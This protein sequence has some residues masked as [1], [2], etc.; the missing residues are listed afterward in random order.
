[1]HRRVGGPVA[2][3]VCT[4]HTGASSSNASAS[5]Q[6]R[7]RLASRQHLRGRACRPP[8]RA[9]ASAFRESAGAPG[10]CRAARPA[11]CLPWRARC[12]AGP[13][14]RGWCADLWPKRAHPAARWAHLAASAGQ[15]APAATARPTAC[16][17]LAAKPAQAHLPPGHRAR[18]GAAR[19]E[20]TQRTHLVPQAHGRMSPT[21][22]GKPRSSVACCG[23]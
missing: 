23:R 14:N 12:A 1:M 6:A 2:L 9:P 5:R 7:C 4:S 22:M 20:A 15:T 21:V 10:A 13:A 8:A 11:P 19:A 3:H 17:W 18:A 16:R